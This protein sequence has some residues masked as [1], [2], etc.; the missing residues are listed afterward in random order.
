LVSPVVDGWR[1][2]GPGC[3]RRA[4]AA[5][6]WWRGRGCSNSS[7][8]GDK[9][10]Q[11][12]AR[13]ASLGSRGCAEVVGWLGTRAGSRARRRLSGSGRGRDPSGER[14]ARADQQA[15]AGATGGVLRSGKQHVLARKSR[16]GGGHR[17]ASMADGGGSAPARGRTG[18]LYSR[19]QGGGGDGLGT[20]LKLIQVWAAAWPEYGGRAATRVLPSANDGAWAARRGRC[21]GSTWHRPG[22]PHASC[23]GTR[24]RRSTQQAQA[25]LSVRVRRPGGMPTRPGMA[26]PATSCA[27]ALWFKTAPS[28]LL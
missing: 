23:T 24:T 25:C 19:V 15:R 21:A 28:T 10:G 14:A 5:D 22:D 8:D 13:A 6:R 12:V 3:C 27:R 9:T 2:I 1:R 18:W 11:C 20:K 16:R 7:E 17:E 4:A 26:I